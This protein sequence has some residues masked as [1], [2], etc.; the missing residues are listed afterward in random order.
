MQ[1]TKLRK[2]RRYRG[3]RRSPPASGAACFILSQ[4]LPA[5]PRVHLL[6]P[7]PRSPALPDSLHED[8]LLG[9]R[10]GLNGAAPASSLERQRPEANTGDAV[11]ARPVRVILGTSESQAG[12]RGRK[13][14]VEVDGGPVSPF[15]HL[16][17]P[18]ARYLL[19]VRP[20][21]VDFLT[22]AFQSLFELDR[23]TLHTRLGSAHECHSGVRL[24]AFALVSLMPVGLALHG[25]VRV[26][27]A[28]QSQRGGDGCIHSSGDGYAYSPDWIGSDLTFPTADLVG[29]RCCF[30]RYPLRTT[31]F[32]SS[33]H[34]Q[35][36]LLFCRATGFDCCAFR[37][38]GSRQGCREL[39][40]YPTDRASG[41]SA[42]GTAV[43]SYTEK[44]SL[45]T[46]NLSACP[47]N[48]TSGA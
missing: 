14:A 37:G 12:F 7:P 13:G 28:G 18:R 20:V 27:V 41:T 26:E 47:G 5:Q 39:E 32:Y 40:P 16:S 25:P 29:D 15:W 6:R 23:D 11:V 35:L 10:L 9:R 44:I 24:C 17:V 31:C 38:S 1:S 8:E 3:A 46:A 2:R 34:A 33:S 4:L 21:R 42:A 36:L 48:E 45:Y 30:G 22:L 19:I 43:A